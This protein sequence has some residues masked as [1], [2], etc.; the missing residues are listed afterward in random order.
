MRSLIKQALMHG[1]VVADL[2]TVCHQRTVPPGALGAGALGA[3]ALGVGVVG[4]AGAFAG[5]AIITVPQVQ[6]AGIQDFD[7]CKQSGVESCSR[8]NLD[9]NAFN[10]TL[11]IFGNLLERQLEMDIS[12]NT[13]FF[14]VFELLLQF[15]LILELNQIISGI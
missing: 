12:N 4:T 8:L 15:I 1:P 13:R 10:T 3:G 7:V 11:N 14:E 6:Q 5:T 9:F 2:K